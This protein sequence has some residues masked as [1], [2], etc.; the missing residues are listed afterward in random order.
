VIG[1]ACRTAAGCSSGDCSTGGWCTSGC[2]TNVQCGIN[3]YGALDWCVEN[4]AGVDVC[5]PGCASTADCAIYGS[6]ST[7]QETIATNGAVATICAAP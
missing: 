1:S 2:T 7:C 5:F 3:A 6:G 4:G